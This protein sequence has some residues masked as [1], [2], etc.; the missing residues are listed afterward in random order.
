[1]DWSK[2]D[3]DE[4][5]AAGFKEAKKKYRRWS[6]PEGKSANVP[7]HVHDAPT[8]DDPTHDEKESAKKCGQSKRDSMHNED[9]KMDE[10]TAK[11]AE[12]HQ[13]E[14]HET[15]GKTLNWDNISSSFKEL[16]GIDN[17]IDWKNVDWEK[18]NWDSIDWSKADWIKI[19]KQIDWG[20]IGKSIHIV[21]E[22]QMDS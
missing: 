18:I 7:E 16:F 10:R 22:K 6:S 2:A 20:L 17:D 11:G 13:E 19:S 4:V 14:G 1:V 15:N 8:E 12:Q 21:H 5:L 3:W 9:I